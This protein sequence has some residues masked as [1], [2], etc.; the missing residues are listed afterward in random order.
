MYDI[1]ANVASSLYIK[2]EQISTLYRIHDEPATE[3]IKDASIALKSL[4]YKL[5]KVKFLTQK[6]LTTL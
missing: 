1:I 5:S 4:G 2:K 6:K 3:K